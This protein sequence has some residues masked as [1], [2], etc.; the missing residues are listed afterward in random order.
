MG[1]ASTGDDLLLSWDTAS[2]VRVGTLVAVAGGCVGVETGLETGIAS[3]LT[4]VGA[5]VG[6]G[7]DNPF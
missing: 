4:D 5:R 3:E 1:D 2:G 6:L 7:D